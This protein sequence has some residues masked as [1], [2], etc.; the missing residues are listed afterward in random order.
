VLEGNVRERKKGHE[1]NLPFGL[2][3]A[4]ALGF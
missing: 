4:L 2:V 1:E 3:L